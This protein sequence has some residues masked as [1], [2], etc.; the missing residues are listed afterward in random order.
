[1]GPLGGDSLT[2]SKKFEETTLQNIFDRLEKRDKPEKGSQSY[3]NDDY[4]KDE[5]LK[6][7]QEFID[8]ELAELEKEKEKGDT[9]KEES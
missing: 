7:A 4:P 3:T 6:K 1:V 9:E 8:N 2:P 5:A